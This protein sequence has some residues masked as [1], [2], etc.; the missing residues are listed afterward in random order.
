[1]LCADVAQATR[2]S[3]LKTWCK[4]RG[5][6]QEFL[7]PYYHASIGFME[8]F[9][10]TLPNRVRRMWVESPKLFVEKVEIAVAIYN[11]TPRSREVGSPTSLWYTPK[12]T[13]E[14]LVKDQREER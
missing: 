7:P 5:I 13:W 10:Q 6:I 8:R 3:E 12:E 4:E 9:N 1:M 11:H 14:Y 2:S